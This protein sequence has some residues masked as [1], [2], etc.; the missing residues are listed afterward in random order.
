MTEGDSPDACESADV[1]VLRVGERD[2]P[3]LAICL[4]GCHCANDGSDQASG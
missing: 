3:K 1:G 2:E 4:P